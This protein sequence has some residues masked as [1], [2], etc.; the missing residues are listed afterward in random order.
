MRQLM[1]REV[2]E[3]VEPFYHLVEEARELPFDRGAQQNAALH[4][5]GYFKNRCTLSEKK[6]FHK[7]LDGF[8][9]GRVTLQALKNYLCKLAQKYNEE[10]LLNSYYFAKD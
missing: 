1:K 9:E 7:K 10:Y 5:W 6:S 8:M 3:A 4:V 2:Q